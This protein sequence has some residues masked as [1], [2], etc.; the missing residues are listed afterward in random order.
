MTD[1]SEKHDS[2]D[3]KGYQKRCY[4][5]K[6]VRTY[7]DWCKKHKEDGSTHCKRKCYTVC[8]V[9]CEKPVTTIHTWG[10]KK[11]YEGKWE[12]YRSESVPKRCGKCKSERKECR[13]GDKHGDRHDDRKY[14]RDD[15]KHKRDGKK[16]KRDD[17]K[18]RKY[19]D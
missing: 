15:R 2:Y 19:Y 5:E 8:E 3:D 9:K 7:E 13:C 14:K 18:S 1:Y 4:C 16:G 11:D 17:K 12:H 6:C 10:Y